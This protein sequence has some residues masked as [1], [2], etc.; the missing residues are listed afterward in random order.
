[1]N[2]KTKILPAAV[3]AAFA[4]F[5]VSGHAQD[6]YSVHAALD[7]VGALPA[8]APAAPEDAQAPSRPVS[9]SNPVVIS[10]GN[11][12]MMTITDNGI[13]EGTGI[14]RANAK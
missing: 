10:F 6:P 3:L 5:P 2:T 1:M 11:G 9:R 14:T 8:N 12:G 13:G 7:D 4:V